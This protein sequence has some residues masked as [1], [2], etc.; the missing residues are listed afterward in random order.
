M[1]VQSITGL[2]GILLLGHVVQSPLG[3]EVS[4]AGALS[5]IAL[6]T[7]CH[8]RSQTEMDGEGEKE[9]EGEKGLDTAS[10]E[11]ASAR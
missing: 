11:A 3:R 1:R 4:K 6:Q 5:A 8:S 10:Q 9:G 7:A 2:Q